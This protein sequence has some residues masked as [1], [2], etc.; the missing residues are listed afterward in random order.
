MKDNELRTLIILV[1]I[2]IFFSI[3]LSGMEYDIRGVVSEIELQE[4][5]TLLDEGAERFLPLFKL[6][7]NSR[8]E[9]MVCKDVVEFT[10]RTNANWW[11]GGH[12]IFPIIYLQPLYILKERGIFEETVLHEFIHY[13]IEKICGKGCPL[14]LNEGLAL[15]FSGGKD[16]LNCMQRLNG[17]EEKKNTFFSSEILDKMISSRDREKNHDGYCLASE[18]VERIINEKGFDVILKGLIGLKTG[19][20]NGVESLFHL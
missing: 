5:E 4:I 8:L 18:L 16:S 10:T 1:I 11:N 9:V 15:H 12:Y 2:T 7:I 19:D 6:D 14:W 13:C 20:R 17:G 3:S